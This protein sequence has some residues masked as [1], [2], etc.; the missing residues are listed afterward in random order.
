[1]L[2]KNDGVVGEV[3]EEVVD[4]KVSVV[5]RACAHDIFVALQL[6]VVQAH[7][8]CDTFYECLQLPA[9]S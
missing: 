1:M 4:V 9:P 6:H 5:D 7:E 8:V 2:A 3:A